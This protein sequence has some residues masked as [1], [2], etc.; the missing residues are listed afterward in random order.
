MWSTLTAGYVCCA[1]LLAVYNNR[2]TVRRFGGAHW[3]QTGL[4]HLIQSIGAVWLQVMSEQSGEQER[5]IREYS[6]L[7]LVVYWYPNIARF[8]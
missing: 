1:E 2:S 5:H 8:L 3:L 4:V 7:L 6:S